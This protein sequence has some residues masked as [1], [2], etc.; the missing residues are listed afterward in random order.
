MARGKR[1]MKRQDRHDRRDADH[2]GSPVRCASGR[3]FAHREIRT[4]YALQAATISLSHEGPMP[5][6][7]VNVKQVLVYLKHEQHAKLLRHKERT[8]LQ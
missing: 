4:S 7:P 2:A 1:A 6:K 5:T 3:S 8:V